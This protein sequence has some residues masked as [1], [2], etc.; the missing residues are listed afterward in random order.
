MLND[1]QL[2]ELDNRGF[3]VI[4]NFIS[5]VECAALLEAYQ[6]DIEIDGEH[7]I[8]E[9]D[10]EVVRAVYAS[11]VRQPEF[12][13]LVRTPRLLSTAQQVLGADVYVYQF[14]INC[15]APFTGGGWSWHQDFT[16]WQLLD[17][18]KT[19]R[20]INFGIFFDEVSEFNGPIVF[21]P[22]SHKRGTIQRALAR[23]ANSS[24]KHLD[25]NDIA[26]TSAEMTELVDRYGLESAKGE[27]GTAILFSPE[28]VHGSMPNVSPFPRRVLIGTY[29]D[30]SNVPPTSGKPREAYLV[31]RDATPLKSELSQYFS[32]AVGARQ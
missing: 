6:R 19:P 25:P 18:L 3:L 26:L 15:K 16:A 9:D 5:S 7:R 22:G 1:G 20:L 23:D 13:A 28:I 31:G 2:Q 21:V 8:F 27:A 11:H 30:I 17:N 14:K 10:G 32:S 4:E 12:H 29:N 24:I